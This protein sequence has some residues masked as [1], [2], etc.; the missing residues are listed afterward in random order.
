[1]TDIEKAKELYRNGEYICVLC[2]GD[3]VHVST[4]RG[5]APMLSFIASGVNLN[6]FSA[7]DKIIGRAAALLF[8]HAGVCEVYA[9]VISS[10]AA[11][12]FEK[13]H[14]KF[15]SDALADSIINRTGTGPCP[16][17]E[18]VKNIDNP[19]DAFEAISN[20]L[21]VLKNMRREAV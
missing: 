2:K 9:E 5:I 16:M 8:V 14:V 3:I 11:A 17:E 1:M 6:G 20:A 19:S 15:S 12:V 7:A 4:D 21:T 18:S 10:H 13:H